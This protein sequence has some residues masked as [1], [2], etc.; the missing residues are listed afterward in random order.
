MLIMDAFVRLCALVA[1]TTLLAACGGGGSDSPVGQ[2]PPPQSGGNPP[3][4]PA[5]PPPVN[6][7]A[8]Y[9]GYLEASLRIVLMVDHAAKTIVGLPA[10][11]APDVAA[12]G[13][14]THCTNSACQDDDRSQWY[15]LSAAGGGSIRV[16]DWREVVTPNGVLDGPDT[17]EL[18]L[19]SVGTAPSVTSTALLYLPATPD[20]VFSA[21]FTS[22][23]DLT[24]DGLRLGN[25]VSPELQGNISVL[26]KSGRYE[27]RD[28]RA[29]EL[30][31]RQLIIAEYAQG[32]V[33]SSW[34]ANYVA[35]TNVSDLDAVDFDIDLLNYFGGTKLKLS[36]LT[37][38]NLGVVSGRTVIES[39][40]YRYEYEDAA[41]NKH[42]VLRVSVDA[43][44]AYLLVEI[45]DPADGTYDKS[46]RLAQA[47]F[48]YAP[49]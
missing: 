11:I 25:A 8:D 1:V 31:D 23:P 45:D 6:S 22:D 41:H 26:P 15:T 20:G 19:S 35:A 3:P 30:T 7:A 37:S 46:G 47:D 16:M 14:F 18:D 29:D 36:T 48:N 13:P 5:P 10:Q 34:L 44:P 32:Q 42:F 9:K 43:D 27:I 38:L 49:Q 12:H 40:R 21:S 24:R 39:G 28:H 33:T 4:D 17:L 2:A